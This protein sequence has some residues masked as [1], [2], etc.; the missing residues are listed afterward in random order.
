MYSYFKNKPLPGKIYE[1]SI[2]WDAYDDYIS[3]CWWN[4]YYGNYMKTYQS[5]VL[6]QDPSILK[7]GVFITTLGGCYDTIENSVTQTAPR[8]GPESK[9]LSFKDRFLLV[10]SKPVIHETEAEQDYDV[11]YCKILIDDEVHWTNGFGTMTTMAIS[12]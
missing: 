9:E 2:R 1:V 5:S 3:T 11:L 8:V 4:A 6:N 10:E 12:T 7:S